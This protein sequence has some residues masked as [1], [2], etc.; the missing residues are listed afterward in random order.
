[1]KRKDTILSITA[2]ISTLAFNEDSIKEQ[3]E[4]LAVAIRQFGKGTFDFWQVE[5]VNVAVRTTALENRRIVKFIFKSSVYSFQYEN[6]ILVNLVLNL[7]KYFNSFNLNLD[8]ANQCYITETR[9]SRLD[10]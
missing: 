10:K 7:Q 9:N 2:D 8:G 1:M 6:Q 4:D 3:L 5:P